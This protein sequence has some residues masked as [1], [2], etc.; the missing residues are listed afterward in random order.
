MFIVE[1][2]RTNVFSF[3]EAEGEPK[4]VALRLEDTF[5]HMLL[6]NKSGSP[7]FHERNLCRSRKDC[8]MS[9]SE[10]ELENSKGRKKEVM[11]RS[12]LYKRVR[13]TE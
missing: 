1:G 8:T 4:R 6:W 5:I 11:Y 10:T 3:T 13:D 7:T 2:R 9:K 12:F